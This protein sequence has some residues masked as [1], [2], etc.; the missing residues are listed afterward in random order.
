M[1]SSRSAHSAT[2]EA[3]QDAATCTFPPCHHPRATVS[4]TLSKK[5]FPCY[6]NNCARSLCILY[7]KANKQGKMHWKSLWKA[8]QSQSSSPGFPHPLGAS[9]RVINLSGSLGTPGNYSRKSTCLLNIFSRALYASY[10]SNT[11]LNRT[12]GT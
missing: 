10:T 7:H 6:L 9:G 5:G 12:K 4:G 3:L 1:D 2:A 11:E 8:W